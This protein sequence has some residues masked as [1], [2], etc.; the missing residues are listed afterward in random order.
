MV[1]RRA[2][3]LQPEAARRLLAAYD[4]IRRMLTEAE[5]L[6]ALQSGTL[7][8]MLTE[9]LSDQALEP[10]LARLRQTIDLETLQAG[11]AW[12]RTL[13][14][15]LGGVFNV[16]NPR[17]IDAVRTLGRAVT[18]RIG[19]QVRETVREA[20]ETGLREGVNP[21][22][23]AKRIRGAVGL[24]P[25]QAKAVE[26][27]RAELLTGDRSALSRVLGRGQIRTPSGEIIHRAAH[28]GGQGLGKRD[29]AMLRA[30]LGEK[31][32]TADQVERMVEAY[33]KRLLALNTEAHARSIALDSQRLAQRMSWQDAIDRGLIA[34]HRVRR[35][36]LATA[37]PQGD[38]RNRPE[39]LEL[40]GATVGFDERYPNGQLVPGESDYNCRCGERFTVVPAVLRIAA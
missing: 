10:T 19:E 40:H 22:V 30:R 29:L 2:A 21:R 37:G 1:Q 34:A 17:V 12:T 9:L 20:A 3:T 8:R 27:F 33:R 26:N 11:Q 32:L 6:R 24:S 39:H 36:W 7:D 15:S 16:L 18:L 23:V 35:T 25:N 14:R 31:A 28:A 13:P 5:L 4:L 38:G